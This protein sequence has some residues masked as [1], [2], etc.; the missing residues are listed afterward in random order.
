MYEASASAGVITGERAGF[1]RRLAAALID[2]VIV[3][4]AVG[5]LE[6]VFRSAGAA[7]AVVF[8]AGY[9]TYMEG[10]PSGAGFGKR[11]LNI[12]VVDLDTGEPIG[13][14]RGFIR[15]IGRLVSSFVFYLGYLWMLWDPEKQ[16]W[17][18]K[19]ARDVVVPVYS[20]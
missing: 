13:Y 19:F 18:D 11:A 12:R 14:S 3:L 4:L 15:Y 10:G 20:P 5:V 17:H 16:C 1:W 6:G 7:L 2:G 9:F 8:A